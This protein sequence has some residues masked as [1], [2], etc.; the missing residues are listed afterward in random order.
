MIKIVQCKTKL[1]MERW[2]H[3]TNVIMQIEHR[4]R[5]V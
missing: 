4:G 2:I 5:Q 1:N 3:E